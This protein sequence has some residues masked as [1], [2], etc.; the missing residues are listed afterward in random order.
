MIRPIN[1][2]SAIRCHT[3]NRKEH[4]LGNKDCDCHGQPRSARLSSF[5]FGEAALSP[6][7]RDSTTVAEARPVDCTVLAQFNRTTHGH[8]PPDR[9]LTV[10]QCRSAAVAV[11]TFQWSAPERIN[12]P[13]VLHVQSHS[14]LQSSVPSTPAVPLAVYFCWRAGLILSSAKQSLWQATLPR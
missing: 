2:K 14:L 1:S 9:N 8:R 10:G 3:K 11:M 4:S 7:S 13:D 5:Q 12:S 6:V